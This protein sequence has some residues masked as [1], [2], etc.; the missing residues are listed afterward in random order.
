MIATESGTSVVLLYPNYQPHI[1]AITVD[2]RVSKNMAMEF[3]F[4][5]L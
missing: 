5:Y 1:R 2:Q 4:S 3:D